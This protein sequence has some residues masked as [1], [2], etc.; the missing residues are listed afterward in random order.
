M[1]I[2]ILRADI[3]SIKVDAIVAPSPPA[4][5]SQNGRA[6]VVSG[7]NLLARFVIEVEVPRA[8]DPD[9]DLRLRNATSDALQK[10]DELAIAI[11]GLPLLGKPSL[12]F[13]R[14]RCAR[15]M[16]RAAIDYRARARSLQRAVFCVF[17]KEEYDIF[18][19]VLKELEGR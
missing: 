19:S 12:G 1:Q 3:T 10:A 17:G 14:E 13:A 8:S 2:L 7:G 18:Q 9:A 4:S 11:I 5:S 16:L 6:V 15:V